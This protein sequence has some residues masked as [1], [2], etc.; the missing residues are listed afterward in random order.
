MG[1]KCTAFTRVDGMVVL[2]PCLCSQLTLVDSLRLSS[3]IPTL[4]LELRNIIL[5]LLPTSPTSPNGSPSPTFQQT[6]TAR[7]LVEQTLD[8]A[9]VARQI[10]DNTFDP[11]VLA[12]CLGDAMKVHCAPMRDGGVDKMMD[13]F[14]K[15]EIVSGL[16][17]GFEVLELMKLVCSSSFLVHPVSQEIA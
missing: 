13:C 4:I 7:E 2:F 3:R 16:R 10:Q 12:D 15:G 6:I 14:R 5:S 1:C 17:N 8:P 9:T 11:S